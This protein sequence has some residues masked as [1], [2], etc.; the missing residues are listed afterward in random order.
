MNLTP[1][2]AH[3]IMGALATC[4]SEGISMYADGVY[5]ENQKALEEAEIEV[6]RYIK[7]NLPDVYAQYNPWYE[8]KGRV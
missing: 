1:M 8:Q 7:T 6:L 5:A 2:M 3:V 4:D